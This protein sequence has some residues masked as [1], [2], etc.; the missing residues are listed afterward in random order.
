MSGSTTGG[1]A[2]MKNDGTGP[3]AQS[4][5]PSAKEPSTRAGPAAGPDKG[6]AASPGGVMKK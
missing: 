2:N 6:D 1:G 3:A 5:A 4:S